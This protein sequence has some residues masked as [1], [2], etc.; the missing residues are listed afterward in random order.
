MASQPIASDTQEAFNKNK[1]FI[2]Q[3]VP[4]KNNTKTKLSYIDK[5]L[6]LHS[7]MCCIGGYMGGYALLCRG[8][9]G[10][11]QTIN[12]IEIVLGILGRN[13]EELLLRVLGLFL[14]F[15]GI[16]CYV[17]L[18][19]KTQINIQRY[20]ILVDMAGF[21]VLTAIPINASK[22]L[23]IL[24]IFFMLSTQWSVF[25]GAKN[26]NS[27]TVFSTNNFFQTVI[28][29][30]EYAFN[31]DKKQLNKALFYM[32]TLFWFHVSIVLSYICV[33]HFS[34]YASLIG[35]VYAI[36]AFVITYIGDVRLP[37]W[38]KEKELVEYPTCVK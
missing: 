8:N 19:K 25:H 35:F 29:L 5:D 16:E 24:P 11:A 13:R 23:G 27:A 34:I 26:Y 21:V 3:I 38:N 14:Y 9:L 30:N 2:N 33:K 7:L 18:T 22:V 31:K 37:L 1:K 32:N 17:L 10:S 4:D 6:I 12:L 15:A 28:A 20:S 36:P